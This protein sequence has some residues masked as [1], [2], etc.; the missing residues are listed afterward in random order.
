MLDVTPIV[1]GFAVLMLPIIFITL[2]DSKALQLN[3]KISIK[4]EPY[5][6]TKH[7]AERSET[8]LEHRTTTR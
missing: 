5:M 2:H 7:R 3:N 6:N 4:L 8:M 1:L